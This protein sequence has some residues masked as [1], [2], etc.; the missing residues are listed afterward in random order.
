MTYYRWLLFL[1]ICM[2]FALGQHIE[3]ITNGMK[4]ISMDFSIFIIIENLL[5]ILIG[6]YQFWKKFLK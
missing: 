5:G 3:H 6:S 2:A 4:D 1:I